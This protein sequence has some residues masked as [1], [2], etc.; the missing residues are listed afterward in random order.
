MHGPLPPFDDFVASGAV[1]TNSARVLFR[2]EWPGPHRIELWSPDDRGSM[3]SFDHEVSADPSADNLASVSLDGLEPDTEYRYRVRRPAGAARAEKVI[4]E[5]RFV[6]A[7]QRQSLDFLPASIAVASC[8]QPFDDDGGVHPQVEPMLRAT[9][10]TMEAHNARALFLLGDQVYSDCPDSSSLFDSDYF[11]TVGPIGRESVRDCSVLEIRKL[12]Q[13]R[14]RRA[15]NIPEW[16]RL[17]ADYANWSVPDDHEIVDNWGA[18]DAHDDPDWQRVRDGALSA[19]FDYQASR[20]RARS[21]ELPE[22]F[23]ESFAYGPLGV[24]LADLRSCRSIRHHRLMGEAQLGDLAAFLEGS[25][26]LQLLIVGLSL[27]PAHVPQELADV[28]SDLVEGGDDWTDRLIHSAWQRERNA[29]LELLHDHVV[30]TGQHIVIVGGDIHA[31]AV[32]RLTWKDSGVTMYQLISSPV[33]NTE[34]PLL[35]KA[36][37]IVMHMTDQIETSRGVVESEI[38]TA[39]DGTENPVCALNI[40]LIEFDVEDREL[41]FRLSLHGDAGDGEPKVLYRSDWIAPAKDA[42]H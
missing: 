40:G 35:R 9:L 30:A 38:L 41:Q 15:W 20:Q 29:L 32:S 34:M 22:S 23:H 42:R 17:L 19:F 25:R 39:G 27:P 33:T 5:G 11:R 26:D 1:T 4:G 6:T 21:D 36:S 31:G 12:L 7:P 14:Y 37:E 24:F 16:K 10:S 2:S 18:A 8:H 13:E 3:R 28:G